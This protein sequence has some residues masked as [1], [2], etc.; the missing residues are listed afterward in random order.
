M[1]YSYNLTKFGLTSGFMGY[2][3]FKVV[4]VK[5]RYIIG[6]SELGIAQ[7]EAY[8]QIKVFLFS[9]L[10]GSLGDKIQKYSNLNKL[11]IKMKLLVPRLQKVTVPLVKGSLSIRDRFTLNRYRSDK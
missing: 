5:S 2:F 11:Y 9:K 6:E 7:V 8:D 10:V 4:F 1:L 3:K